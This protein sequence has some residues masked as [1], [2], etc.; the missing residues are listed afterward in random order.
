MCATR[1][2]L[3]LLFAV[4]ACAVAIP[5]AV[6]EPA[7]PV[8]APL[9]GL[10]PRGLEKRQIDGLEAGAG[11]EQSQDLK[12]SSSYGY[13]FYG[14]YYPYYRPYYGGWG[15]PYYGGYAPFYPGYG[16]GGFW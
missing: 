16:Y 9:G 8:G 15:Y 5:A 12:G 3:I 4:V 1:A 6:P 14:G 7:S 13:G 11:P 2:V 10:E